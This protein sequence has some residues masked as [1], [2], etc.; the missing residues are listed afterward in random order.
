MVLTLALMV[1]SVLVGLF[2]AA[3]ILSALETARQCAT[4]ELISEFVLCVSGHT[5]RD[6]GLAR[7][8][9]WRGCLQ[10]KSA[11]GTHPLAPHRYCGVSRDGTGTNPPACPVAPR[12]SPGGH[13]KNIGDQYCGAAGDL[14]LLNVQIF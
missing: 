4:N 7:L 13:E 3:L 1:S 6:F 9:R 2:V 11:M 8:T 10:A 14:L 12:P 5:A